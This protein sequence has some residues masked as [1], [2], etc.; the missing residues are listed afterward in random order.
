MFNMD[1]C[2]ECFRQKPHDRN[3]TAEEAQCNQDDIEDYWNCNDPDVPNFQKAGCTGLDGNESQVNWL[4]GMAPPPPGLRLWPTDNRVHVYW[5]NESETTPDVRLG[6]IDFES[7]R[8]WRADNWT[9]PFGSSI[10]N[11]PGSNLWQLIAEYDVVDSF[12]VDLD[13]GDT[14]ETRLLPLG[15]NTGLER[16]R[17]RPRVLDDPEFDGLAEA[18]SLVAAADPEGLYDDR[19]PLFDGDGMPL[20]VS[21]PWLPWQSY[22]DVL[23]TFWAV[24]ARAESIYV[25]PVS[26]ESQVVVVGKDPASFYEYVD[27]EVHNG[28]LYFYSVTATDHELERIPGTEPAEFRIIGPGQSGDPSSSFND[29]SPATEAQTAAD[30]EALG[31][32]IYVYPN[33]ATREALEEFQQLSPSGDDPTGVR[34]KFANL[35]RAQNTIEIFTAQRRPRGDDRSTTAPRAT[36]RSAGTSSAATA[37]R[38]SAAST[39]TSWSRTTAVRGLHRQ[40][41]GGE[42]T[43]PRGIRKHTS[44]LRADQGEGPGGN[45]E[46]HCPVDGHRAGAAAPGSRRTV[47]Q[48]RHL[49]RRSSSRSAPARAHRHG[50]GVH[51]RGRRREQRLL[52]PGW[53]GERGRQRGRHQPR[54]VAGGHQ[55]HQHRLRHQP[56]IDSRAP[57]R[58]RRDRSGW[59]RC[60]C[61]PAYEPDGNGQHFDAGASTFGFSYSRFWTDKFSAGFTLSYI[62]EGLAEMSVNTFGFDFGIMYRIGVKDLKLG[63]AIQN[64]GGK[65]TFDETESKMPT[66][67]KVGASFVPIRSAESQAAVR[68]RVRAS[69]GQPG[70]RERGR[71]VHAQPHVPPAGRLPHQLRHG[72]R[73]VRLRHLDLHG[74]DEQAAAGLQRRR[75]GPAA[76]RAP[77]LALGHALIG[78]ATGDRLRVCASVPDT[79]PAPDGGVFFCDRTGFRIF[80]GEEAPDTIATTEVDTMRTTRWSRP[81]AGAL[82]VVASVLA[83]VGTGAAAWLQPIEGDGYFRFMVD[84]ANLADGDGSLDVVVMIAVPNGDL[85]FEKETGVLQGRLRATA[86]LRGH[87]G[88]EQTAV[89]SY[90]V[91]TR[92]RTEAGSPTL[93]QTVLLVLEGVSIASGRLE[94]MVEDLLRPRPG[95]QYLGTEERA[96]ARAEADWAALPER[97]TRGLAVGDAVFLAHAPIRTWE[98]DGRPTPAGQGG[99]WDFVNPHRRYGLETEQLQIYFTVSPPRRVEDRRRAARRPLLVRIESDAM[100]FA[101]TDTVRTTTEVQRALTAGRPAAIYWSMDAGGLPPGRFRLSVAPLDE[102]GRGLLARFDVVWSLSELAR[103][104]GDL[105]GEGRTVLMGEAIDEFEQASRPEQ[106]RILDEFW[107]ELDPTPEDPFNEAR[108]EFHRRIAHVESFLGGFDATGARDPRG[109]IYLLLGKPD[110][111]R[112]EVMPMNENAVVAARDLVFDRFRIQAEGSHGTSPWVFSDYAGVGR[113]NPNAASLSAFVPYTYMAD[114]IAA[115]DRSSDNTRSFLFWSYDQLGRQLFVNSYTGLGDG[116]RFLFIDQ[117]G[118]GHYKLDSSN[119]TMPAD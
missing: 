77:P 90:R 64:L 48:G 61:A 26:G 32:D 81:L 23:D 105:L 94:V 113:A 20:D 50:V 71:R 75:H 103:S 57:W 49:R 108:A 9:R 72:R 33:P 62:H 15:P 54:R 1:N 25:D 13:L 93:H 45:H 70:A 39:C 76:V 7:Y 38:S 67:F 22:P 115:R 86:T 55:P 116:L 80:T 14:T 60:W 79:P 11:G 56:A 83:V 43:P 66:Q 2:F 101:L 91:T 110:S 96:F 16:I 51:R 88:A 97:E 41:R 42:V 89:K 84:A 40:I 99:P 37:R 106:V 36:A 46:A 63:M 109:R 10:E 53:S 119:V 68:H 21:A 27:H 118:L 104:H 59:T 78:P 73:V 4:V 47:R 18:S 74:Q 114:V 82:L 17:Y 5:N 28:F 58:C 29:S 112:E 31:A 87:D 6:A 24:T 111:V 34:V 12:A 52:E 69:V 3:E 8:I 102:V 107:A 65:M 19:P 44:R 30:R 92:S 85:E 35:P 100:Q 117:T 98:Q 95:L